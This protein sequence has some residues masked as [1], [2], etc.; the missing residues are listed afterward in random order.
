MKRRSYGSIT[1]II[2]KMCACRCGSSSDLPPFSLHSAQHP[3]TTSMSEL[4]RHYN[5]APAVQSPTCLQQHVV[6]VHGW[7]SDPGI[8]PQE[9]VQLLDPSDKYFQLIAFEAISYDCNQP[10]LG[11]QQSCCDYV[12]R[13][14]LQPHMGICTTHFGHT[15][16]L[17]AGIT[18]LRAICGSY[19]V[20]A[21]KCAQLLPQRQMC[22]GKI[23]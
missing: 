19:R 11:L 23:F 16:T 2:G 22:N 9:C 10:P 17:Q 3:L 7:Y 1:S 18:I 4:S 20:H 8:Y 21:T 13:Y 12:Q 14:P 15:D 6:L 5:T